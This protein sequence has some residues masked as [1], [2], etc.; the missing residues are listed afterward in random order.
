MD[1]LN[2]GVLLIHPTIAQINDRLLR[3]FAGVLEPN[4]RLFQL[5]IQDMPVIGV[6]GKGASSDHQTTSVR[7]RHTGLDAELKRLAG[8]PLPNALN[9]RRM[10]GIELVFVLWLLGVNTLCPLH[11]RDQSR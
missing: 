5:L 10:Q 1:D 4:S 7:D 11:E 6:A 9:F 8:L 2:R 3:H